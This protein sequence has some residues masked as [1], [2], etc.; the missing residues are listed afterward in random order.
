MRLL[1]SVAIHTH[2]IA[3]E[4]IILMLHETA[5]NNIKFILYYYSIHIIIIHV[6]ICVIIGNTQTYM[7]FE[8]YTAKHTCTVEQRFVLD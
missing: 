6:S 4:C 8:S 5:P 2:F 7:A 3:F 1:L